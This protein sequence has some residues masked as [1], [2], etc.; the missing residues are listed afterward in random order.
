MVSFFRPKHKP[1]PR[2]NAIPAS[3]RLYA[4]GDIHGR[5][6]LLDELLA[7]IE[8]DAATQ[9]ELKKELIFLGD[10]IDRGQHSR[11]V[12]ARL[13]TGPLAGFTPIF[14]RGNHEDVMLKFYAGDARL[15]MDWLYFGGRETLASYGVRPPPPTI[16]PDKM[17][18]VLAEFKLA[19]PAADIEFLQATVLSYVVGDYSFVHAGMRP[20]LPLEHQLREDLLYI[21]NDFLQSDD[22]FG[23]VVVHGHTIVEKPEI[24]H[25]RISIDTGAYATG[26]LT[27]LV[28]EGSSLRFL[29]T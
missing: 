21:R 5:L 12:L 6:D 29:Q 16:A 24:K 9:P 19:V 15:G 17:P 14:L 20:G 26:R 2:E 18:D 22:D 3:L 1:A 25:N 23:T 11:Q 28:L 8:D 10:Y 4:I 27:C 7:L 13:Q